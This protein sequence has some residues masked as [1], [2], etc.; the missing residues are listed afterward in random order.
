ML[1]VEMNDREV[2]RHVPWPFPDG[3]FPPNLGVVVQRTVLNGELPALL[4]IHDDENDWCV[5]DDV[6]DP[7]APGASVIAHM[8]HVLARD[9]SVSELASLP[10]GWAARR[11]G[12]EQPWERFRHHYSD[13]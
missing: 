1:P 2:A 11:D 7:N 8:T 5:G 13:E 9:A 4:L 6:N 10:P 12:P 3:C